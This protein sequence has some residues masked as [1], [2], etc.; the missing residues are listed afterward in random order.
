MLQEAKDGGSEPGFSPRIQQHT[1]K[2]RTET[3]SRRAYKLA[4]DQPN[5]RLESYMQSEMHEWWCPLKGE[6]IASW[7]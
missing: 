7:T 4:D 5:C 3:T 2:E 1:H 6:G